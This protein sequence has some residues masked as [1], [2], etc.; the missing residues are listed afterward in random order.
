MGL[1]YKDCQPRIVHRLDANTTGVVVYAKKRVVANALLPQFRDGKVTKTYL[2]KVHGLPAE[3]KFQCDASIG[4]EPDRA[5]TR[6]VDPIGDQALTEFE[7][8]SQDSGH[9]LLACYPKT[10]RTNQIRIHLAHLG[11]PI[12][13]DP[14]YGKKEDR[15]ATQTLAMTDPPMCLHAWKLEFDH[16]ETG[17]R[18]NFEAPQ[19][20]WA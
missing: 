4:R 11:F 18:V 9:S 6:L 13:G 16:P 8:L 5:G 2:A 3:K 7:V 10:G 20:I 12:V 17:H 1:V 15:K 19:P 14:A